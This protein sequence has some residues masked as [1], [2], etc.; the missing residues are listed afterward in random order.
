METKTNRYNV[1]GYPIRIRDEETGKVARFRTNGP[2]PVYDGAGRLIGTTKVPA[3][4]LNDGAVKT[5][6]P[7]GRGSENHFWSWRTRAG[8]SGWI[9]GSALVRPPKFDNDP[10]DRNPPPPQVSEETLPIDAEG[11]REKLAGL[12]FLNSKGEFPDRGG[13]RGEHYGG[14]HR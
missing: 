1:G 4:M 7:E 2:S 10:H 12:R 9:A 11:G 5:L 6:D 8:G 13:N 14:R 3:V